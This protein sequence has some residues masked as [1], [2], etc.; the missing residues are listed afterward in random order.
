MKINFVFIIFFCILTSNKIVLCQNDLKKIDVSLTGSI[1]TFFPVFSMGFLDEYQNILGGKKQDFSNSISIAG[2]LSAQW[3]TNWRVSLQVIASKFLLQDNFSK[4]TFTGSGAWRNFR[5]DINVSSIPILLSYDWYY[6]ENAYKSYLSAGGGISLS[7]VKW[8]EYVDSPIK[9]DIR[10]GGI[11]YDESKIY[12]TLG[13]NSGIELDFDNNSKPNFIRGIN[14]STYIL[15]IIRYDDIYK[16]MRK[17]IFP[18]PESLN[19]EKSIIPFIFGIHLGL[20]LNVEN[21]Q[22]NRVFGNK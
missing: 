19:S 13:F 14:L 17:Q 3:K 4:E 10:I 8:L 12:P 11:I 2:T 18:L 9:N 6:L 5:E 1:G 22:I 15:Y 20:V 16:N 7:N 21:K